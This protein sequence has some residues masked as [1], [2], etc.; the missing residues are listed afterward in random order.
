MIDFGQFIGL[1]FLEHG[2]TR[3]GADC[4]GGARMVLAEAGIN[5]PDYG[6]HYENTADYA[7]IGEA[8]SEGLAGFNLVTE[9]K[10]FDVVIFQLGLRPWHIGVMVD[11]HRFIHWPQPDAKGNDGTSRIERWNEPKWAN[12]VEGFYRYAG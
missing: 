9:P 1:P 10:A 4:W 3:D 12:R 7:A 8:I 2:R 6:G 5:L 11:A